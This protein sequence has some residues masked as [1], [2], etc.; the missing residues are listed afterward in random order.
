MAHSTDI[1]AYIRLVA[2][3]ELGYILPSEV[4]ERLSN[5]GARHVVP[6][7]LAAQ[8][9]MRSL[10]RPRINYGQALILAIRGREL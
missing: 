1:V 10:P 4:W 2:R 6:L 7:H 9:K 5:V 3:K 8:K